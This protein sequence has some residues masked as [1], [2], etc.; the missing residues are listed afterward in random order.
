MSALR[1]AVA[2]GIIAALV[3]CAA[4]GN[5]TVHV[6]AD[7]TSIAGVTGILDMQFN[8]SFGLGPV[9]GVTH[10][11]PAGTAVVSNFQCDQ[12]TSFDTNYAGY[13]GWYAPPQF[14]NVTGTPLTGMTIVSNYVVSPGANG[15]DLYGTF[16]KSLSFDVTFSGQMMGAV[17]PPAGGNVYD[18]PNGFAFDF[19]DATTGSTLQTGAGFDTNAIAIAAGGAVT[20][21]DGT[22]GGDP[23][24]VMTVEPTPEPATMSLLVLGA[25]GLVAR[26]RRAASI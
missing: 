12:T 24:V 10:Q 4:W 21:T 17:Q 13:S 3:P 15:F 18:E 8:G 25:A 14:G 2:I 11:S 5:V 20:I 22:N 9:N 1:A 7:T 16:G 19:L 6:T 26:R 23:G